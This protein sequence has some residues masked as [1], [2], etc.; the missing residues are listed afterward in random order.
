MKIIT[1]SDLL[2][3]IA[4]TKGAQFVSLE[5][6]SQ[7]KLLKKDR[8]T[9][10][11]HSFGDYATKVSKVHG[12]IHFDYETSV[13]NQREREEK[14]SDFAS[15][16]N[17][18]EHTDTPAIVRHKKDHSKLYLQLKVETTYPAEWF[19]DGE[20][21]EHSRLVNL[22]PKPAPAKNQGLEKEVKTIVIGFDSIRNLK[23]AGETYQIS[24]ELTITP[25]VK[26][27]FA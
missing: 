12:I 21:V 3:V 9:K 20:K 16:S 17:W 24:E 10:E 26:K 15:Q 8:E 22:L 13:N 6:A 2:S 18:F 1:S 7:K 27:V 19:V 23:I 11:P 14:E 5:Y 25:A 4:A